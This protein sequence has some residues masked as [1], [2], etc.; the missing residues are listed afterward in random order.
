MFKSIIEPR[1]AVRFPEF[2]GERVYMLPF[3]QDQGLPVPVS[4]W[5]ATV[6][7]MLDGITTDQPIYLMVD[8]TVVAAGKPQRR[9]GLHIDGYWH[10]GGGHG[11][12][13][14]PGDLSCHRGQPPGHGSTPQPPPVPDKHISTPVRHGSGSHVGWAQA[15]FEVP[16]A[17]LLASTVTAARGYV[18]AYEGPIGE[19]GDCSHIDLSGLAQIELTAGR[20]YAGNV[21]ALHESLPLIAGGQRSL[22]RLNIPGWSP[23][24]RA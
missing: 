9:P 19:G 16:E 21:T 15:R 20:A 17:I 8:E 6:D 23:E 13:H 7:A 2:Q 14:R 1:G 5:Q 22:V 11:H 18:G 3:F 12:G 24:L 4:R 10:A